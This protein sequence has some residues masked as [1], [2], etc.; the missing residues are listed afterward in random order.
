MSACSEP[1][2]PP[3]ADAG[4]DEPFLDAGLDAAGDAGAD[5]AVALSC[6]EAEELVGQLVGCVVD[7]AG[8]PLADALVT[9]LGATV[10]TD[11]NGLFAFA[12]VPA[13]NAL[14]TVEADGYKSEQVTHAAPAERVVRIPL[15]AD[16]AGRVRMLFGGDVTF[17]R[18]FLDTDA[19]TP[20]D[21]VPPDDP[22]ALIQ[23]SNP[24]PGSQA[25]LS[26]IAP[27]FQAADLAIVNL[28]TALTTNPM[29]P[30]P[31]KQYVYFSLPGSL[32]A[33]IGIGI[34]YVSLGNNHVYD[35]LAGGLDDTLI[36]L[37]ASGIPYSGAG[38]DPDQAFAPATL[39]AGGHDYAMLSMTSITGSQHAIEYVASAT[40][41]GAADLRD[42]D[43][44]S[45]HIADA[46]A[47]GQ[48]PV[49]QYHVGFEYT[50]EPANINLQRMRDAIDGGAALTIGHHTHVAQ[51]FGF[52]NGAL[53]AHCLGNLVFDQDRL[54]TMLGVTVR[55]D[56]DGSTLAAARAIPVYLEDYQP[57]L[58]AGDLAARFLRRLG[59]FSLDYGAQVIP[60]LGQGWV[61]PTN[62]TVVTET[63]DLIVD[64]IVP[65]DGWTVLDLRGLVAADESLAYI[66]ASSPGV[67]MRAGRDALLFG[68]LE[69][70]DTDTDVGELLRWDFGTSV[71]PCP[72]P[73]RGLTSLCS[74]RS[75][76]NT[77]P[78][79][80]YLRNRVRVKGEAL[81]MP[82]KE[83]SLLVHG[84]GDNAG[85]V[86]AEVTYLASVGGAVFG[87]DDFSLFAPG[88][89]NWT[90]RAVDLNLP[91]DDPLADPDDDTAHARAVRL[92]LR[93]EQPGAGTGVFGYDDVALIN[94]EEDVAD[95]P[96]RIPHARDFVRVAGPPGPVTLTVTVARQKPLGI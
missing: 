64:V 73:M 52:Y 20:P 61:L 83:M 87:S 29:D 35:Y 39:S 21:Q 84:N 23:V 77:S 6:A 53:L 51:G 30:H 24:L 85:A 32:P 49:V 75:A 4:P 63:R 26:H 74:E 16:V 1:V 81:G 15:V 86:F 8:Q 58:I 31:T 57:R 95:A 7:E 37:Q 56:M 88:T 28:E 96:I 25:T 38:G 47:A 43:R 78:S 62:A 59:E 14:V 22:E 80:T 79:R 67:N 92:T 42:S 55:V 46:V 17:G 40:Q 90:A 50:Y 48:I 65:A 45:M 76:T 60:Y 82:N 3:A 94:W 36:A 70:W 11:E 93:H 27:H 18:R 71:S 66:S 41:G 13:G 89:Y 10:T 2:D 72:T 33:L 9:R 68:D 34:D 44:V 19:S 54:E 12:T 5:A 91:P 69:D